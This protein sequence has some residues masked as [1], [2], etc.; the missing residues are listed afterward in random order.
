MDNRKAELEQMRMEME[1]EKMRIDTA[2]KLRELQLKEA[3]AA[4]PVADDGMKATMQQLTQMM[5][6]QADRHEK[7]AAAAL[8]A[9]SRPKKVV[10]EKNGRIVGLE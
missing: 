10:R 8:E 9:L 6:A 2:L 1:M 5:Q 7:T 3:Q 4:A